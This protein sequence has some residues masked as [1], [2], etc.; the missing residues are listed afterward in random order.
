VLSYP[1]LTHLFDSIPFVRFDGQMSAKR[2]EEAIT[3]F[4]APLHTSQTTAKPATT[5]TNT[6]GR[7]A[8][9]R[10]SSC[11]LSF[12]QEAFD[13][14]NGA[15]DDDDDFTMDTSEADYSDF[16]E[17]R[18][19]RKGKGKQKQAAIDD[20]VDDFV[21]AT[22]E[23]PAVMLLSLKAVSQICKVRVPRQLIQYV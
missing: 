1:T 4:S 6:G 11:K 20:D 16:E 3:R 17:E 12:D 19:S 13:P 2:R 8:R 22:N 9:A 23:N 21:T 14:E 5:D 7:S 15:R 18:P 10:R